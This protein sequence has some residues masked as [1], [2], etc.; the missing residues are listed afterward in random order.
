MKEKVLDIL[1]ELCDD[2]IVKD[3]LD[4][5]L[6]ETGL[7]DSLAFV[8]LLYSFEENF[9]VIISP[10]EIQRDDISTPNKIINILDER[11]NK[12]KKYIH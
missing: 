8:E 1:E 11:L 10:S 3:N 6:F 5:D 4:I 9:G 2:N 7:L 12:W